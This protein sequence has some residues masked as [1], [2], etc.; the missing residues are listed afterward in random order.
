MF[1]LKKLPAYRQAG[2]REYRDTTICV[3]PT[4]EKLYPR[5]R[6]RYGIDERAEGAAEKIDDENYDDHADERI[7]FH[8]R[9]PSG[10]RIRKRL[11]KDRLENFRPVERRDGDHV[12]D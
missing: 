11:R 4:Q 1:F 3:L 6:A 9:A 7:H 2:H 12:E 5:N 8:T 10:I